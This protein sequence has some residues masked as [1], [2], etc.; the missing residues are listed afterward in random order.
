M[1]TPAVAFNTGDGYIQAQ[2]VR[3]DGVLLSRSGQVLS[4]DVEDP[5]QVSEKFEAHRYSLI[6]RVQ[7][8]YGGG[9]RPA[10][11]ECLVVWS[12]RKIPDRPDMDIWGQRLHFLR[13]GNNIRMR[14]VDLI[15]D[16]TGVRSNFPISLAPNNASSPEVTYGFTGNEFLVM[17]SDSRYTSLIYADLYGQRLRVNLSNRKMSFIADNG[18]STVTEYENINYFS[19]SNKYEGGGIGLV[20]V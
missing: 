11:E 1:G 13:D 20:S 16:S 10:W 19:S 7:C 5:F 6:P 3:D 15:G 12:G 14:P 4:K 18:L 8:N 17:W 2:R 9:L